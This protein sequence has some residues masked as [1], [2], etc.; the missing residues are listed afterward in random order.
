MSTS[1]A[2]KPRRGDTLLSDWHPAPDQAPSIVAQEQPTVARVLA[3]IGLFLILVGLI[4]VIGPLMRM[5]RT[6]I[7]PMTGFFSVT[8]GLLLV[9]CH[10]FVDR[11]RIFRRMYAYLGM[12]AIAL[13][14]LLRIW[15]VGGVVG[16]RFGV[17]GFPAL[18]LGLVLVIAT[19]RLET[20]KQFRQIL[21][22]VLGVVGALE[23]LAALGVGLFSH[24]PFLP[25]EGGVHLLVGLLYVGAFI[26][27]QDSDD[28]AYYAGLGL[29]AVGLIAIAGALF[30]SMLPESIFL[31]PSGLILMGA[32]VVYLGVAA[33]VCLDWP[34]VVVTRRELSSY[35]YSPVA[36]LVLVGMVA[37]GW[38]CFWQFIARIARASMGDPRIPPLF[39]PV[40]AMYFFAL[41]PVIVQIFIVPAITMRIVAEEKRTGTLEVLLTAPVNETT[42]VIGKFLAA[43]FFYMVTWLPLWLYL[44]AL[45]Y[46][47]ETEF[48]YRPLL[49]FNI[50]M[51]AV[52]AGFV[53]M[54]LFFSAVTSNQI[55]AAVL[56]FVGMITWLAFYLVKYELG[57]TPGTMAYEVLAY[58]SFL[59]LWLN[60][61]EGVFTPRYLVFHL[62]VT[63]FFLYATIKLLEARKWM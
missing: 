42:I 31:V 6:L 59:D 37:L 56:T 23:I 38:F 62:S 52:S 3:L 35:F 27:Q 29:G 26:G 61:L 4:P 55:I 45:R 50:T 5:E 57:L 11:D 20:E 36:Y 15:P 39:E 25:G 13:A 34:I 30:R 19:V 8:T 53:A 63:V 41:I 48:D 10:A 51:L 33:G 12:T 14:I 16:A 54:G 47:G 58:V 2:V 17:A 49:S 7:E 43:F 1:R 22:A 60:A 44:V 28:P 21:L 32:G 9:L 24:L 40:V 18:V 46:L